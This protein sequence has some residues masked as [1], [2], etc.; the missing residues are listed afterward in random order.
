[1]EV[2]RIKQNG[3]TLVEM[4]VAL[5]VF[6]VVATISVGALLTLIASNNN[7][8]SEQ[9]V[10]TNLSF[11]LDSMT[12]E[13]RTGSYYYCTGVSVRSSAIAGSSGVKMFQ[14]NEDLSP[15]GNSTNNCPNGNSRAVHGVSFIEGGQSIT[16]ADDTRI[17][18]F[19]DATAGTLYR[20]VSGQSAQSIISSSIFIEDMQFYVSGAPATTASVPDDEQAT[21][22]ITIRARERSGSDQVYNIQTTVTQRV[23][24]I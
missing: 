24:D 23:L 20:M 19:F 1:M 18:Y 9:N 12:R 5:A 3:F 22:T 8:Q 7:A 6:S 4:I 13:L 17:V 15:L 11:A 16:G 21:V 10:M 2:A 14:D